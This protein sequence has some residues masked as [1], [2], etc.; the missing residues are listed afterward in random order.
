MWPSHPVLQVGLNLKKLDSVTSVQLVKRNTS[1]VK[2]KQTKTT[3]TKHQ[4]THKTVQN[5]IKS[6]ELLTNGCV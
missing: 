3:K 5:L 1:Q 6:C 2:N 4:E